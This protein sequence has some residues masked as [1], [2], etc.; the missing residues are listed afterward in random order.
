MCVL[1][2]GQRSGRH[3]PRGMSGRLGGTYGAV[4]ATFPWK[5]FVEQEG[6]LRAWLL[7]PFDRISIR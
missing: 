5:R 2:R 4:G 3:S 1:P 6:N 7:E